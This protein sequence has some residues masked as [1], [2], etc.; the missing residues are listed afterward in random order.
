MYFKSQV[1][2]VDASRCE[3]PKDITKLNR[4]TSIKRRFFEFFDQSLQAGV[5]LLTV[6]LTDYRNG[7]IVNCLFLKTTIKVRL[8]QCSLN[9]CFLKI[10]NQL[11]FRYGNP[12]TVPL[13]GKHGLR[14]L[15]YYSI[16]FHTNIIY[17]KKE[18]FN[19]H[20]YLLHTYTRLS[21]YL[22]SYT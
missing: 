22:D 8:A 17:L 16:P 18:Q 4:Q 11:F 19:A 13:A 7:K 21:T 5:S 10:N 12:L 15:M 9:C 6:P 2:M 1:P 3:V 14:P 20:L